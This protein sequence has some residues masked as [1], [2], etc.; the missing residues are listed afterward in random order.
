LRWARNSKD[1][2]FARLMLAVSREAQD[3]SFGVAC[4]TA[5]CAAGYAYQ[6]SV[7]YLRDLLSYIDSFNQRNR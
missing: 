5:F 3:G 6:N 4:S 1:P 2:S 7:T